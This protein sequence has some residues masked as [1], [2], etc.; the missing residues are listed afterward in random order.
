[1]TAMN[2][3]LFRLKDAILCD[4]IRR[5]DNGKLFLIG[6]Y[7]GDVQFAKLPSKGVFQAWILGAALNEGSAKLSF[8]YR[9]IPDK[10]KT[11]KKVVLEA[12]VSVTQI[13]SEHIDFVL[14]KVAIEFTE[15]GTLRLD[16]RQGEKGKW[17]TLLK[18]EVTIRPS[19]SL[20]TMEEPRGRPH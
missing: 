17:I 12:T 4:D 2:K 6:V 16:Y 5:E 18:K 19:L 20:P 3:Q 7:S 9:L 13:D 15:P 1:M 8:R 14:P 11:P 10:G